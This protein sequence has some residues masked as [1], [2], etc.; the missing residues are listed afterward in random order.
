MQPKE[1]KTLLEN[2]NF[3][4]NQNYC[5][6]L[7]VK[8]IIHYSMHNSLWDWTYKKIYI[9][10]GNKWIFSNTYPR[11]KERSTGRIYIK[12]E[13]LKN[14]IW[15]DKNK[16]LQSFSSDFLINKTKSVNN[17]FKGFIL[18][19]WF[20]IWFFMSIFISVF[21]WGYWFIF[22]L[23]EIIMLIYFLY[24]KKYKFKWFWDFIVIYDLN[25]IH[26]IKK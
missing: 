23:F 18:F 25:L 21:I 9:N 5:I 26:F 1:I 2:E 17:G 12:K 24:F 20:I 8:K 10:K 6:G 15:F 7:K 19:F 4:N 13:N 16:K 14:D 3:R 11:Y 22:L